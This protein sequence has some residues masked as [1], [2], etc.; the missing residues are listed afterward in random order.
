M[1]KKIILFDWD[2]TLFSKTKY[3]RNVINNLSRLSQLPLEEISEFEAHYFNNLIRSDDFTI[4]DFINKF[5]R[6]FNKNIDIEYFSTDKLSI[7]SQ[8]LFPETA[9]ILEKIKDKYSLGI[10]SQ[11]FVGLQKLKIKYSGIG[12]FFDDNLIFIDRNKTRPEFV[13]Q[14]P[15]NVTIVDDKKEVVE[16]L[17]QQRPDLKVI[18]MNRINDEI[19]DRVAKIQNLNDLIKILELEK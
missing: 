2:D 15:I 19:I 9:Q 8:S 7:Y 16:S 12:D 17:V 11:G 13:L 6:Q 1:I 4:E 18:W 5:S 14:I 10:Y 3:R